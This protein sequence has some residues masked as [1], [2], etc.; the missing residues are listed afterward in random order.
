MGGENSTLQNS[1]T[2]QNTPLKVFNKTA[3]L[4][5][6]GGGSSANI[7]YSRLVFSNDLQALKGLTI[8]QIYDRGYIKSINTTISFSFVYY[9]GT[10]FIR[11]ITYYDNTYIDGTT[12]GRRDCATTNEHGSRVRE[13]GSCSFSDSVKPIRTIRAWDERSKSVCDYYGVGEWSYSVNVTME[14]DM[15]NFCKGKGNFGTQTCIDYCLE[16][17]TQTD[18][19]SAALEHCFEADSNGNIPMLDPNGQCQK[20]IIN[21]LND[22]ENPPLGTLTNKLKKLCDDEGITPGNYLSEGAN[23]LNLC[24]C[25]FDDEVYATFYSDLQRKIPGL[26]LSNQ[27]STKCIFPGCGDIAKFR[28]EDIRGQ[29]VCPS[30]QCIQGA[31]I[32]NTGSIEGGN[33][34]VNQ[35]AEC[36]NTVSGGGGGSGGGSGGGGDSGGGGITPKPECDNDSDC[37]SGE[38]CDDDGYCQPKVEGPNFLAI[39]IG[40]GVAILLLIILGVVAFLFLRKK[41]PET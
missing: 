32:N 29:G 13:S 8:N 38:F 30:I 18:C 26:T 16:P 23:Y 15:R 7:D 10:C 27:K 41:K 11:A 35:S 3:T 40:V 37:N 31:T 28:P 20:Y 12:T 17:N 21:Y 4:S 19:Y 22:P 33:I 39:G 1:T 9:G 36:L 25:H 24:A 5:Q 14:I 34:S 6:S 2:F